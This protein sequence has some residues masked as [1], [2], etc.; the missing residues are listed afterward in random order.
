MKIQHL[1]H[2]FKLALFL[3]LG[4]LTTEQEIYAQLVPD[5][6]LPTNS[7]VKSIDELNKLI[8]GGTINGAN[9]FHSFAEFNVS[10]NGSV[11]FHNPIG[12]DNILTRV[13][14]GN[15]SHILGT[16]GVEGTANLFLINPHGIHFGNSA[17]LDIHGSFTA[18]TA[19]SIKLGEDG[20]FSANLYENSNLL[21]VQPSAL[22]TNALKNQQ[23]II[24]NQGNLEVNESKNITL[25][26][27]NIINT[28]TLT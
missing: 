25:L 17:S 26:G 22:F 24:N 21:S 12:I 19:D 2:H 6:T 16:L 28:G 7:V 23:A 14:G 15:I 13:T 27:A 10:E 9:L 20:L 4:T 11:Y 5:N 18:T 8:E 3:I 1:I